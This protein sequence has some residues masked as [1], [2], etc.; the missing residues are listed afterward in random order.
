MNLIVDIPH[1]FFSKTRK[2]ALRYL[3]SHT[4][5]LKSDEPLANTLPSMENTSKVI[6]SFECP[7]NC[8]ILRD[9]STSHRLSVESLLP[10]TK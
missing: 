4:L 5:K 10:E 7:L 3:I 2:Q 6:T 9:C 8:E 1:L